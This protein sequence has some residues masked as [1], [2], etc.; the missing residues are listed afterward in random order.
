MFL[1]DYLK[2]STFLLDLSLD[3]CTLMKWW[4]N[5][6]VI[7]STDVNLM[8]S[9]GLLENTAENTDENYVLT[10]CWKITQIT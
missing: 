9:A 5:I 4:W 10:H 8:P 6:P 3:A 7:T 2:H 1:S